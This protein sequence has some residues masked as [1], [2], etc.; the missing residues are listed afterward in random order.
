VQSS[1]ADEITRRGIKGK[2]L[3]KN[4]HVRMGSVRLQN[5][6]NNRKVP[7]VHMGRAVISMCLSGCMPVEVCPG[8]VSSLA[9]VVLPMTVVGTVM[10][11]C[12]TELRSGCSSGTVRKVRCLLGI[13]TG[14]V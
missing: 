11:D 7:N 6:Q 13:G 3:F 8:I 10:K 1:N 4:A 9:V 12:G 14:A 5:N 2:I